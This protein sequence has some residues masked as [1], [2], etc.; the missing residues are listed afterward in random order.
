MADKKKSTC[1][2]RKEH[3][4]GGEGGAGVASA[5]REEVFRK[6]QQSSQ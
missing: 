2:A 3:S 4:R 1:G 6:E 5:R